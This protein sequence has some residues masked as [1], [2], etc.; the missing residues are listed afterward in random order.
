MLLHKI[1]LIQI[2]DLDFGSHSK[3]PTDLMV[4]LKRPHVQT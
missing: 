4:S 1:V 2:R 3:K